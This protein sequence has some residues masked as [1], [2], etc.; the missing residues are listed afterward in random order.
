[1]LERTD[2]VDCCLRREVSGGGDGD[3]GEG[4]GLL[5]VDVA[6]GGVGVWDVFIDLDAGGYVSDVYLW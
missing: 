1:M 4:V 3:C 2:W 6:E 5:V